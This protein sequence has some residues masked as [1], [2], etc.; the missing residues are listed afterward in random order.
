MM[1]EILITNSGMNNIL[2]MSQNPE[3]KIPVLYF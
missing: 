3:K 2:I 1:T